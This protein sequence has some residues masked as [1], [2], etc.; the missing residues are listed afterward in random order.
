MSV[1][2]PRHGETGFEHLDRC[3]RTLSKMAYDCRPDAL[4]LTQRDCQALVDAM[5]PMGMTPPEGRP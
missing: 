2:D 5:H 4:A 3:A 1:F